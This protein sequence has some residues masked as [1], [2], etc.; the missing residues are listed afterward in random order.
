MAEE[1][2]LTWNAANWITILLMVILGFALL[3]M[4]A[5]VIQQK[6]QKAAA[7]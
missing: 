7:A 5:K 3:G 1:T 6:R 2:I 4:I